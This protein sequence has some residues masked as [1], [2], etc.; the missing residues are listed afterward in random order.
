M[1]RTVQYKKGSLIYFNGDK[2]DRIFVLQQGLVDLATIDPE[3]NMEVHDTVSQGE[4]FGVKSALSGYSRDETATALQDSNIIV[5]SVP[6][7]ETLA[8]GNTRLIFKML[9]VFSNQLRR[10]NKQLSSVLKQ[11]EADPDDGLYN[12]GAYFYKQRQDEK[13]FYVFSKYKEQY[14]HGKNIDNAIKA[15]SILKQRGVGLG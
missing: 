15:L 13:A 14:P 3:I 5:F 10:V 11:K 9:K 7:F 1:P 8:M 6:E 4:F 2:S 12:V